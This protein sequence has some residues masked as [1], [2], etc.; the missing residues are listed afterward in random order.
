SSN[1]NAQ[2][3]QNAL[4]LSYQ[5]DTTQTI[6]VRITNSQFEEC[7]DVTSFELVIY[8]YP[9]LSSIND[10]YEMCSGI[11]ITISVSEEYNSYLWSDESTN[12][13]LLITEPGEYTITVTQNNCSTTKTFT[14]VASEKATIV[15]VIIKDFTLYDNSIEILV[16]GIGDYEYSIGG[17]YQTSN[18]FSGVDSGIYIV[19]VRDKN[20]CGVVSQPIQIL[21]YPLYFT[22]NQD[23]INDTWHI[24]Y[25]Y[26]ESNMEIFVSDRYGKLITTFKDKDRGWDGT[27]NGNISPATD[28][29]FKIKRE[30]GREHKGHFSLVR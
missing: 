14:A 18:V 4:P 7:F 11:P 6:F 25:G 17:V 21:T 13:S 2:L 23:G 28:Y 10:I 12:A 29:W 16:D 8:K 15:D 1:N 20:G 30:D 26:Y 19:Y 24:K 3:N 27:L 9:N 5:A 22:P